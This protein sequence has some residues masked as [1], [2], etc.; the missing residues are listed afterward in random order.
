MID[1]TEFI[2]SLS[3]RVALERKMLAKSKE[4]GSIPVGKCTCTLTNMVSRV[5]GHS[6]SDRG[7]AGCS[8]MEL[9]MIAS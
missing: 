1:L 9:K 2:S 8:E 3:S 6:K 5:R 4:R 7:G